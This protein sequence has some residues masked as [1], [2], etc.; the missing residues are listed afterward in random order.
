MARDRKGQRPTHRHTH[1]NTEPVRG[2]W[3]LFF[4]TDPVA[5]FTA[6][7]GVFTACLMFLS[8]LQV[9]AFIQ[10]ERAFAALSTIRFKGGFGAQKELSLVLEIRNS[11]KSTAFV[12][13][14]NITSMFIRAG[15]SPPEKPIYGPMRSPAPGPILANGVTLVTSNLRSLD[16]GSRLVLTDAEVAALRARAIRFYIIGFV[17][18]ADEFSF[19]GNHVTGFCALYNPDGDEVATFDGCTEAAYTYSR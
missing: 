18:F 9:L 8:G 14:I 11:G 12:D 19:L 7:V 10:S 15:A 2:A 3:W 6:W 16:G 4:Q 5:G 13:E 17:S 1:D